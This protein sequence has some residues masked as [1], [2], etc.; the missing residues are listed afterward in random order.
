MSTQPPSQD[1]HGWSPDEWSSC[2]SSDLNTRHSVLSFSEDSIGTVDE[3]PPPAISGKHCETLTH[4]HAQQQQQQA[5]PP[6]HPSASDGLDGIIIPH[7]IEQLDNASDFGGIIDTWAL[8][9]P[10]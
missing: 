5:L 9:Q 1:L 4:T 7:N 6:Q 2:T 3:L 8:R 10:A